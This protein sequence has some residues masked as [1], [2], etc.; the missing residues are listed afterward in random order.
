[1]PGENCSI[2]YC[3]SSRS[4]KY[5]GVSIWKLLAQSNEV[6]KKWRGELEAIILRECDG[7]QFENTSGK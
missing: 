7:C 5:N 6:K 4:E 3:S 1:M 2:L